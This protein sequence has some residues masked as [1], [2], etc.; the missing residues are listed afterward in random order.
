[1]S[2]HPKGFQMKQ[3]KL[4]SWFDEAYKPEP[5]IP[6]KTHK[7]SA[8]DQWGSGVGLGAYLSYGSFADPHA[9]FDLRLAAGRL[10]TW[11]WVRKPLG[12]TGGSYDFVFIVRNGLPIKP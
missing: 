11:L 9:K 4:R 6:T 12:A 5:C 2:V 3:Y 8:A 7:C 1:M 10:W